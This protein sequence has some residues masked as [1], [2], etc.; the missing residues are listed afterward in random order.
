MTARLTGDF[1][2]APADLRYRFTLDG[3]EIS[4]LEITLAR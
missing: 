4:D 2:G 3:D 1:P